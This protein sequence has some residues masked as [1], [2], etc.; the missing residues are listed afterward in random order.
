MVLNYILTR[1]ETEGAS[2]EEVLK[3]ARELGYVEADES[4][5]LD[6]I[7]AAHKAVILAYLAHGIWVDLKGTLLCLGI[8]ARFPMPNR[9]CSQIGMQDQADWSYPQ[10]FRKESCVG[11]GL[12]RSCP[13]G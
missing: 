1:M 4:L 12:S 10:K 8:S 7:D 11:W 9:C 6:G 3:D 5:D 2:F 13:D